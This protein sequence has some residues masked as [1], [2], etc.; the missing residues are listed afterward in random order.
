MTNRTWTDQPEVVEH[1][2]R[3]AHVFLKETGAEVRWNQSTGLYYVTVGN[4]SA[5]TAFRLLH[6][7]NKSRGRKLPDGAV[8]LGA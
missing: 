6:E 3:L 7:A 2:E 8:E 4:L 5:N 1:C